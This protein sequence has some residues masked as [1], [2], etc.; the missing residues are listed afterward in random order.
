MDWGVHGIGADGTLEQLVDARGRGDGGS[1][2][3]VRRGVNVGSDRARRLR[4][5][6]LRGMM[7]DRVVGVV[8]A[9]IDMVKIEDLMI[10]FRPSINSG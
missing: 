2:Q 4:G 7:G 6:E 9:E 1:P 5:R 8:V 3:D 10:L